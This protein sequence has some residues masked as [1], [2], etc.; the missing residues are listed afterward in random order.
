VLLTLH[1]RKA[2]I[3]RFIK[4]KRPFLGAF[5]FN[6][7][8][9][10]SKNSQKRPFGRKAPELVTLNITE[11]VVFIVVMVIVHAIPDWLYADWSK[12][13]VNTDGP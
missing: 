11:N 7:F 3:L 4:K 8:E 2:L 5:Y 10:G 6:H 1:D 13:K 12:Q 9:S